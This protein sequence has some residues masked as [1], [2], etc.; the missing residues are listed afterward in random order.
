MHLHVY[1][2][3]VALFVRLVKGVVSKASPGQLYDRIVGQGGKRVENW[4]AGRR[5]DV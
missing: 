3:I 4:K 1:I 2:D 5:S